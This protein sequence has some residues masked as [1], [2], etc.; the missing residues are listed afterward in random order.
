MRFRH[1]CDAAHVRAGCSAG[2]TI[3]A[4]GFSRAIRLFT[5][6]VSGWSGHSR[7]R[8]WAGLVLASDWCG[9]RA[10]VKRGTAR[11]DRAFF[12][13]AYDARVISCKTWRRKRV[14]LATARTRDTAGKHI[15]VLC[16]RNRLLV[17]WMPEMET[18]SRNA[19]RWP[20]ESDTI[21]AA[22]LGRSVSF[23]LWGNLRS[24]RVGHN[25]SH[26]AMLRESR[27]AESLDVHRSR[28]A[29]I[30]GARRNPVPI[31]GAIAD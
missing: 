7:I 17:I 9:F 5:Y 29:A 24:A 25:S 4:P 19:D 28:A 12:R 31:L 27:N 14:P 1:C 30:L 18:S 23:P 3:V 20:R 22:P 15:E 16:I 11:I 26:A 21:P 2:F 10:T 8:C 13:S 6:A